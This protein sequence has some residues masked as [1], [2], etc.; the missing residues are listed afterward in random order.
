LPTATNT[1]IPTGS[2][3]VRLLTPAS[4]SAGSGSQTFTWSTALTPPP[5]Q[6]FELVFWPAGESPM[7]RGFGMAAPTTGNQLNIN[8]SALDNSGDHPL[9]PG[10]YQWGLLLVQ[11]EPSY[12]RIQ[13]L[14]A[15]SAFRYYREGGGSSGGDPGGPPSTGE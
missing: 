8:L 1:P 11:T 6:A 14:G 9:E 13:F 2:D 7:A 4:G 3:V 12:Q 10:D 5:G 15:Q